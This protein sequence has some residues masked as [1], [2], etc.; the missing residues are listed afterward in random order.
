MKTS[1]KASEILAKRR[2]ENEI[3]R[4]KRIDEVYEKIPTM[5]SLEKNI[6]E[7]GFTIINQTLSGGD[8]ENLE[9]KLKKLRALKE[10]LL[11]EN[12]FSKD[13]MDLKYHHDLCKDTGF[14]GN[15]M[16]SCRKQ[17]IIDENYNLSNIKNLIEKE[18]F[19]NFDDTLFDDNPYGNYPFTPRENIRIVKDNLMK[20]INNF[21]KESKNIYI[22]GAVGR[23]KTFLLNS[24]AKELL[25]R[26]CS[27]LYMT[28]SSLFKFLN[29]YNWAFEEQRYKH[30]EKYDFILD[31]DLLIID[32]LGSEY[33]SKNN[34]SNLF[35]IVNTRMIS[36]KPILFSTNYDESMLSDTYGPRIFSRIVGNSEVYEIFGKDLRLRDM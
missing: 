1:N 34:T 16:C 36:Q 4:N 14:V 8:T 18:N 29:D 10:K 30:Q 23:G 33:P 12:G 25:D 35:D 31:C 32:D 19:S 20:Y 11:L 6:K 26:N 21:S 24:V 3:N 15:E 9:V 2:Q 27:V 5:A 22:F 28:S 17:I 7:L 13:Y